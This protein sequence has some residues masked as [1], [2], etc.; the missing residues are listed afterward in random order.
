M[1]RVIVIAL[2]G[3][4]ASLFASA[5]EY[6]IRSEFAYCKLNEGKT[7]ADV[8]AQ[9]ETYGRFSASVGTQYQQAIM[10]PM[11][12]G[13]A[14]GYDYIIWGQWPS[15][16][17]MYKEWGS[18]VNDYRAWRESHGIETEPAGTC[19]MSIAMFNTATAHSR[20]PAAERDEWQP[21][22]FSWCRLKEGKSLA[23]VIAAQ[24]ANEAL[25]VSSGFV[26][27]G[28]HVFTPYLGFDADWGYDFVQMNHW[29]NFQTRGH[30]ADNWLAF[31]SEHPAVAQ[32]NEANAQCE[33]DRSFYVKS[34]FSNY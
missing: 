2:I 7:M 34:V 16:E 3:C 6:E 21:F 29:Y 5:Q 28:T 12:A 25:M 22:Q 26:G 20:I 17:Q 9:S 14:S 15:G 31:L 19:N 11:H 30:M 13:D 23:D 4:L 32:A 27:W 24:A 10:R 8:V 33:A 1:M 18:F